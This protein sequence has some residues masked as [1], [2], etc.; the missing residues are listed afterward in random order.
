MILRAKLYKTYNHI[1]IYFC[2]NE[3]IFVFKSLTDRD[4]DVIDCI[5]LAQKKIDWK[6][7][8]S[9]IKFQIKLS[10]NDV[11]VTWFEERLNLMED[12]GLIIPIIKEIRKLSEKY[13]LELEDQFAN[14]SKNKN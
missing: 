2:S 12:K 6:I 9:E 13:Y 5:N 14:K 1:S 3:D 4:G 11:W 8:L 10:G 7:I